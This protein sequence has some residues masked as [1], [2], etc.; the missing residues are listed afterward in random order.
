MK[1]LYK[2]LRYKWFAYKCRTNPVFFVEHMILGRRMNEYQ[3]QT[4]RAV[5]GQSELKAKAVPFNFK[6]LYKG[7]ICK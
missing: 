7:T 3:R 4:Y 2:K 6:S 1:N 5:T